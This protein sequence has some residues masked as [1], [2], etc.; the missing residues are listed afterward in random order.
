MRFNV[1]AAVAALPMAFAAPALN[2]NP[3]VPAGT[4]LSV[5][6]SLNQALTTHS[7]NINSTLAQ[8]SA[9]SPQDQKDAAT[10]NV[11]SEFQAMTVAISQ[12]IGQLGDKANNVQTRQSGGSAQGLADALQTT[13]SMVA[14]TVNTA[15]AVL[16][17]S[18]FLEMVYTWHSEAD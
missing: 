18:K 16:G 15:V 4:A 1:I 3:S 7:G 17:L 12:A 8:M 9:S 14:G 2:L 10:K 13:L 6:Q 5:V 11:G